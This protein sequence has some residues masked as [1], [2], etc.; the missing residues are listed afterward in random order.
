VVSS[1]DGPDQIRERLDT[2]S[3]GC[4]HIRVLLV[5]DQYESAGLRQQIREKRPC[6]ADAYRERREILLVQQV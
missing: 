1:Q 2:M 5:A 6:P 4:W 3:V